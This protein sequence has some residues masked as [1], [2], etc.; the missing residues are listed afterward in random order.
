MRRAGGGRAGFASCGASSSALGGES[1]GALGGS[2]G[3]VLGGV[4]G[5][6]VHVRVIVRV[7][8]RQ[9][10]SAIHGSVV[11]LGRGVAGQNVW[12]KLSRGSLS[13]NRQLVL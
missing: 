5:G 11:V 4:S 2:S 13:Y 3:S 1:G 12:V 8:G 6:R 7:S 9:Q 10:G